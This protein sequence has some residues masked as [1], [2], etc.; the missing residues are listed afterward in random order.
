MQLNTSYKQI[1]NIS[2]PIMLGSAAQN[3]IVL[4]DSIFL[5]HY[6][7]TQFASIGLIGAFYL[8]LAAIGFGFSRGGQIFI[9]RKFGEKNYNQIG[10]YFQALMMFELILSGIIFLGLHYYSDFLLRQFIESPTIIEHCKEYLKYRLPGIFF[11]YTGVVLI[12][13]YTGIAR[14]KIILYDT[15]ILALVNL[16]LNY[17]LVF[18]KFGFPAMGIGGSALASTLAEV[19]AFIVFVVY[20]VY[21]RHEISKYH[22]FEFKL[23]FWTKIKDFF[24]VSFP[25]VLQSALGLCAYF[26][27]F[28]L[29]ENNSSKDLEIAN[30][31]RTVYLILSIPIWGF[32]AGINTLVSN[33]IGN[34]KRQGVVPII[35]KTM[36]LSSI[37]SVVLTLIVVAFP[38]YILY[39]LFGS[40]KTTLLQDSKPYFTML[41]PIIL[42]F[43]VGS[44]FF[45]G[46]VGTGH[47]KT[48]LL[49]QT[50][51]TIVYIA[52]IFVVLKGFKANLYWAW[53]SEIVYWLGI[54]I[55]V[56]IYLL[57][58]KWHLKKI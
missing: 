49:I 34:N 22:L 58:N 8:I 56:H 17:I 18:G 32:S 48:A 47:T 45:N 38:E 31:I 43:S 39:P 42:T 9:A 53:G 16:L 23:D 12:A 37:I 10:T 2:F 5:Y 40:D 51:F 30:I 7:L 25:I 27:F 28:T 54:Y 11:S 57:T 35:K 26:I 6:D 33:F 36:I 19:I 46:L 15:I 44:I 50:I 41:L 14:P 13:F 29:I 52:Y 55:C 20:M 24:G 3:V 21:D 4:S 1:W